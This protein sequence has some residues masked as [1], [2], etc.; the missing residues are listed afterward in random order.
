MNALAAY[1]G[2][3]TGLAPAIRVYLAV[4]R[5]RGK[6]DA[7]RFPERLGRASIARP[8]GPLVW[9]HAASLG[10]AASL[11]A[12][13]DRLERE[14]P[15]LSLLVTTGTVTSARFLAPRL[16][17]GR[18]MHQFVPVDR[19]SYVAAFL[20]TW[21]PDLAVWVESELWPNLVSTVQRRG[22][23]SV[24]LNARMS[25]R[26][27]E[28]WR[29]W[30]GLVGPLLAGFS[31]CL[32]QDADQAARLTR[33]GARAADSVGDLKSAASPLP[34]DNG[35]LE[36]LTQ[37]IGDRPL[38]LAASTHAGEEA[39]AAAVHQRL[40]ARYGR[41]LTIIVPRH[42][43]RGTEIAAMLAGSGLAIARRSRGE[44]PGPAVDIYLADTLGE[45]GLFYRLAQIVFVGGSLAAHGGHNPIE[46]ALLDCAI[47]HGP[48][49]SNCAAVARALDDG[50]G[51]V[52]VRGVDD[53]A[54][55]IDHLL[56]E[57][58]ERLR[59]ISAA[60]AVAAGTGGVLDRILDRLAPWLDPLAP[61]RMQTVADGPEAG[62][63]Y[64]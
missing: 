57:P 34:V 2:L 11:L 40:R 38:W 35:E 45:L 47:L 22:V 10:E 62:R 5:R 27:Y 60:R 50:G 23:P 43:A 17:P 1:R 31:L 54:E 33:L 20:D 3:T 30:P 41:L 61:R 13:I 21:R 6:E 4:R 64:A 8:A 18:V 58:A 29:R 14:R 39:A 42:P 44:P 52:L 46:P 28:R 48:D 15:G 53:L 25:Q 36:R 24:L 55:T 32:A 49:T 12:L 37:R 59:R 26:S 19:Q 63:A 51:A 56:A 16:T 9:L 7:A